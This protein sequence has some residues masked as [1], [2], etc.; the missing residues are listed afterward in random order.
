MSTWSITSID[1]YFMYTLNMQ[2]RLLEVRNE[3]NK[4]LTSDVLL[5]KILQACRIL[6]GKTCN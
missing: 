2:A 3:V 6:M 5:Q 4:K 1:N